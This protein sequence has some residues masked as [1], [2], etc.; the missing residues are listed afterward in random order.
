MFL[1]VLLWLSSFANEHSAYSFPPRPI[2]LSSPETIT[3]L[4]G[5][6]LNRGAHL[7]SL[8]QSFSYR[9]DELPTFALSSPS[10][11]R[12][13]SGSSCSCFSGSKLQVSC[14]PRRRFVTSAVGHARCAAPLGGVFSNCLSADNSWTEKELE[15]EQQQ[16]VDCAELLETKVWLYSHFF[17]QSKRSSLCFFFHFGWCGTGGAIRGSALPC[18]LSHSLE[19]GSES[20]EMRHLFDILRSYILI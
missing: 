1:I 17:A 3:R 10:W 16:T 4:L 11:K 15:E 14:A 12:L 18:R 20:F 8:L 6:N 5:R 9:R 13:I 7:L 2:P 19:E